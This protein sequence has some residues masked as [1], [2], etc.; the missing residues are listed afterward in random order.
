MKTTTKALYSECLKMY[1]ESMQMSFA[2]VET[3]FSKQ[4]LQNVHE[5]AKKE[6]ISKVSSNKSRKIIY[7]TDLIN[8]FMK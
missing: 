3:F 4:D 7:W 6:A 8:K 5:I 1:V 2:S